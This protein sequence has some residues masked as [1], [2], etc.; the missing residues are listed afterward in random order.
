MEQSP[1]LAN[2][3]KMGVMPENRLVLTMAFPLILSMLMQACYNIVDSVFVAMLSEDALT[4]VSLA[5]PMQT[6]MIAFGTGT[7]VGMNAMLSKSLGEKNR[8][9]A[10]K[11]A[12]NGIFLAL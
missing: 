12:N 5:F 3:N 8:E 9:L 7:G 2:E 4:A 1:P 10:S 6:V 11:A